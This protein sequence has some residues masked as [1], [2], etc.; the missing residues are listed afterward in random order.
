MREMICGR[1]EVKWW[2]SR[3]K[4]DVKKVVGKVRFFEFEEWLEWG[5]REDVDGWDLDKWVEDDE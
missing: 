3:E 5:G 1:L 2:V 4:G